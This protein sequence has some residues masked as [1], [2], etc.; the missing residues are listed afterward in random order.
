MFYN[1]VT[2][3][4]AAGTCRSWEVTAIIEA[5]L[6]AVNDP[7]DTFARGGC[8]QDALKAKALGYKGPTDETNQIQ[9]ALVTHIGA[10]EAQR[11]VDKFTC[12]CSNDA[13][14]CYCPNSR[15]RVELRADA[16][17][18]R[19]RR[20]LNA[21]CGMLDKRLVAQRARFSPA[22]QWDTPL[23]KGKVRARCCFSHAAAGEKRLDRP[24]RTIAVNHDSLP[25]VDSSGCVAFHRKYRLYLDCQHNT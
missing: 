18:P 6:A 22:K 14:T 7:C 13:A 1:Q 4:C 19:M 2:P 10:R 15:P 16:I 21:S 17:F 23:C 11:K 25:V 9:P 8:R 20:E 24:R 5:L 12:Q 3:E